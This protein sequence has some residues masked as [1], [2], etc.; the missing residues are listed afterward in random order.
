V[1]TKQIV[2]LS[3]EDDDLLNTDSIDNLKKLFVT[4][5]GYCFLFKKIK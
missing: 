4:T 2:I 5:I 3:N 1:T